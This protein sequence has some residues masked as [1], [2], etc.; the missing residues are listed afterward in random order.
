MAGKGRAEHD[1]LVATIGH[2]RDILRDRKLM[3]EALEQKG[4]VVDPGLKT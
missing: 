3:I 1:V 2:L 4:K